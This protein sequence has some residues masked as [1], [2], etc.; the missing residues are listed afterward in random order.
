MKLS[1][2]VTGVEAKRNKENKKSMEC[3][4]CCGL[5]KLKN[6]SKQSKLFAINKE[7]KVEPRGKRLLELG[8]MMLNSAKT[9]KDGK[10]NECSH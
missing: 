8:S 2:I 1:S 5:H 10:A 6:C 7:K 4:L 9:K 3:F